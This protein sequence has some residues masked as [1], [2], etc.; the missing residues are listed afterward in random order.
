MVQDKFGSKNWDCQG[1]RPEQ[2]VRETCL[3]IVR[4]QYSLKVV[5]SKLRADQE[6]LK[7]QTVKKVR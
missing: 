3:Y 6:S 4:Q 7:L 2:T 1:E 5:T